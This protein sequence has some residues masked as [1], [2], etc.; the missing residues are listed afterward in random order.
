[1]IISNALGALVAANAPALT[2]LK[3]S[4]CRIGEQGWRPV[5][6][7]LRV[8]THLREFHFGGGE[9]TNEFAAHV[10]LPAVR[11]NTG[12]RELMYTATYGP[13]YPW[14]DDLPAAGH[15]AMQLVRARQ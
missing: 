5:F 7:A 15:E 12:L 14:Q 2:L 1:M 10:L 6:E 8:N 4:F 13:T 9:M 3:V 11:A